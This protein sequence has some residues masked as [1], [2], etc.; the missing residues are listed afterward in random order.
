VLNLKSIRGTHLFVPKRISASSRNCTLRRHF[1]T[2]KAPRMFQLQYSST[3]L[4]SQL[5]VSRDAFDFALIKRNAAEETKVSE[6]SL[7]HK[8]TKE[9]KLRLT[10][11]HSLL[12]RGQTDRVLSQ[13]W[14]QS[15]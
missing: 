8:Q 13:R 9:I 15:R 4:N 10:K 11:S 7:V 14:M 12:Q 5:A 1:H 3:T 6:I 2:G